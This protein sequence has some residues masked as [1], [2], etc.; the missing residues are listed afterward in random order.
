MAAQLNFI[1]IPFM[2]PGHIIPMINMAQSLSNHGAA[3]AIILTHFDAARFTSAID[4]TLQSSPSIR[5][6]KIRFPS[7]E[8]GLPPT[9]QSADTLPSHDL[10]PN[11]STAIK[12]LQ[13]PVEHLLLQE[14]PHPTCIISDKLLTWTAETCDKLHLPRI[15]FDGM[16]CF[17]QLVTHNLYV[18][19][20]YQT[21]PPDEPFLVPGL[22]DPVEVTRLQLPGLFNPGP[23]HVPGF[24]EK[25]RETE[26]SAYGVVVN[27]FEEVE[28]R[29]IDEFRKVRG[30]KVWC[31]G[32]L[33]L[34]KEDMIVDCGPFLEWLDGREPASVVYSCLGSLSSPSPAQ[35]AELALGLEASNHPFIV[36]AKGSEIWEW[37][38]GE[39]IEERTRERGFFVRDWAPQEAILSRPEVGAFL[40]HCGWN[41]TLEGICAGVP[42]VT[43]PLFAEQFLNEKLVVGILGIGVGV[44]ARGVVH[45]GE[46]DESGKKVRR[47]GIKEAIEMVMD[48]GEE[49]CGRRKRAQGFAETAKGAV[50]EGGSSFLNLQLLIQ[51]IQHLTKHTKSIHQS[52]SESIGL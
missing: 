32:P 46:E 23:K 5:L 48:K 51:E 16:N 33:S 49:A 43:W 26:A 11:F 21:V 19:K 42:M 39:G 29:Y 1:L 24:R 31:I 18:S 41:S 9:C 30:G 38:Q 15:V 37:I 50:R 52:Q 34:G 44:G 25:V 6:L 12:M 22:P 7:S 4:R 35:F 28:K 10:L 8:A 47:D 20:I 17:T 14:L 40:T 13:P 3:A 36:V 27:S 2:A 45:V